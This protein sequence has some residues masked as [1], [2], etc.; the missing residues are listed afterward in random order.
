M[1]A[2]ARASRMK[3]SRTIREVISSAARIFT[4]TRLPMSMF[5]AS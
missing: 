5:S 1:A 3:R 2:A 4:A